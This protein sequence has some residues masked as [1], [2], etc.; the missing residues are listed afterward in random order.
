MDTNIIFT[1]L[2]L[3]YTFK[4]KQLILILIN[5]CSF[6]TYT[7]KIKHYLLNMIYHT[8]SFS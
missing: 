4:T 2:I 7:F 3:A 8:L 1:L 5:F 6:L